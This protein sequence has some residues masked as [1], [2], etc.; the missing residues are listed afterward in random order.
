MKLKTRAAVLQRLHL[1]IQHSDEFLKQVQDRRTKY[2]KEFPLNPGKDPEEEAFTRVNDYAEGLCQQFCILWP[3][4]QSEKEGI[5]ILLRDFIMNGGAIR[6]KAQKEQEFQQSVKMRIGFVEGTLR[7]NIVS[8]VTK[9]Q[10]NDLWPTISEYQKKF[11]FGADSKD[12][13]EVTE[14]MLALERAKFAVGRNKTDTE[15]RK[16]KKKQNE[17]FAKLGN[18]YMDTSEFSR[19]DDRLDILG[20]EIDSRDIFKEGTKHKLD[21]DLYILRLYR[22]YG[23]DAEDEYKKTKLVEYLARKDKRIPSGELSILPFPE[24]L[25]KYCP[26]F[27]DLSFKEIDKELRISNFNQRLEEVMEAF[28]LK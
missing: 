14:Y 23:K 15:Y 16:L 1:L 20:K 10:L 8:P 18:K 21:E 4:D 17:Q 5:M 28:C 9:K 26:R 11:I 27:A 12:A 3:Q 22:D 13:K 24:L 7:I 6:F 25:V 2:L 19:I